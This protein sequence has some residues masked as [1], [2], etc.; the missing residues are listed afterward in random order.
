[1]LREYLPFGGWLLTWALL[2]VAVG[3]ADAV[4]LLAANTFVQSIRSLCGLEVWPMLARRI[5]ADPTVVKASRWA[6]ARI[7]LVSL[8]AMAVLTT[9]LFLLMDLRSM[10]KAGAML[11]IIAISIVARHP[12]QLLI[13]TRL[14]NVTWRMG[15]AIVGSVGAALVA[16]LDL[17][18]IGA[19]VV[20]ALRDWGG[21]LAT[22]AFAPAREAK[23]DIPAQVLHFGETATRTE[24]MARRRLTYRIS[25]GLLSILLGPVGGFAARTGRGAGLNER[26]ARLVPRHRGGVAAL[27]LGTLAVSLGALAISREPIMLLLSAAAIRIAA[28]GGSMLLWW[29]YAQT[30]PTDEDDEDDD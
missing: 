23:A 12:G 16:G 17:G 4:R 19:A 8:L 15:A 3:H 10:E 2:G 11:A 18:W 20:L 26:L 25:K 24:R 6:A 27:A 9:G 28:S 1:M 13:A 29:N 21:L 30:I 7:D 22:L 5:D 14:R